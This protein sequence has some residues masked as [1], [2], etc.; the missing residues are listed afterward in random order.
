MS[1]ENQQSKMQELQQ[2]EQ[3]LQEYL[4]QKQNLQTQQV[5]LDS[6]IKELENTNTAYK[7]VGNIMVSS[8]P[9]KL[10]QELEN[11][12]KVVDMKIASIEKQEEKLREK[13]KEIQKEVMGQNTQEQNQ[14]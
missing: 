8:G 7:I 5:E 2:V 14:G 6:G 12:K 10:K 4:N 1:A 3:N 11:K 13:A 9:D